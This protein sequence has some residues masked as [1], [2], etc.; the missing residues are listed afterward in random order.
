MKEPTTP[1][2]TTSAERQ[3]KRRAALN[4]IAE[5]YGFK[6]WTQLETAIMDGRVYIAGAFVKS[7]DKKK[8]NPG[9][10]TMDARKV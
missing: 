9:A 1:R 7:T 8:K 4:T 2:A 6:S 5:S 3:R 10:T